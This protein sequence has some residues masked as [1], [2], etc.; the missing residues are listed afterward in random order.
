MHEVSPLIL[1]RKVLLKEEESR[2]KIHGCRSAM[3]MECPEEGIAIL[4]SES[5]C[6]R[7]G[8][9]RLVRDEEQGTVYW[10]RKQ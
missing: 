7:R 3:D 10:I 8:R 6:S 4:R 2:E 1:Q 9:G 5:T